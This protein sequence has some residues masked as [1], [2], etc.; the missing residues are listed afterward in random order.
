MAIVKGVA[1]RDLI[2]QLLE[3]VGKEYCS[4][5]TGVTITADMSDAVHVEVRM[6]AEE[7]KAKNA[8]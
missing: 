3:L 7:S 4:L 5:V 1:A 6:L 8:D 2:K